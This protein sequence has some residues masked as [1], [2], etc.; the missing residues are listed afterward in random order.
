MSNEDRR[1]RRN[2][3]RAALRANAQRRAELVAAREANVH[4]VDL[5]SIWEATSSDYELAVELSNIGG[6]HPSDRDY[7][8][9]TD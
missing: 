1:H 4:A 2:Y 8:T 9:R 5:R 3:L 6:G 7:L